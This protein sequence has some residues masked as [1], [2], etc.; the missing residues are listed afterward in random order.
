M[1]DFFL[2]LP[3]TDNPVLDTID[4]STFHHHEDLEVENFIPTTCNQEPCFEDQNELVVEYLVNNKKTQEVTIPVNQEI[5]IAGDFSVAVDLAVTAGNGTGL[6]THMKAKPKTNT[7]RCKDYR[8][9]KKLKQNLLGKELE[10][11]TRKNSELKIKARFLDAEVNRYKK[12]LI[13]NLSKT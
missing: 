9:N 2:T 13:N 6:K 3:T 5:T 8:D 12:I 1:N 4:V 10:E 7:Q 11:L